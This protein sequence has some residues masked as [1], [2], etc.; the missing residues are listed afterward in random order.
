MIILVIVAK[1]NRQS[2]W[3]ICVIYF[4]LA[5]KYINILPVTNINMQ[6]KL[7]QNFLRS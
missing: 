1:N 7:K 6:M 5:R 2:A 3:I 4:I